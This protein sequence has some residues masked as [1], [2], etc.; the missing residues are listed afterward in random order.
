MI[1]KK[2]ANRRLYDMDSSRYVTLEELAERI[3]AGADVKVLDAKTNEDFTQPT[4]AQIILES[5]GASK[6]CRR[7]FWCS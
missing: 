7:V 2:Y 3:R 4:L 1:V 5:R 6:S